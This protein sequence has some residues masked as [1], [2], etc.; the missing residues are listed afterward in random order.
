M[1]LGIKTW[2][3]AVIILQLL[4]VL[5]SCNSPS[6]ES[7]P[8]NVENAVQADFTGEWSTA[9]TY[10][11]FEQANLRIRVQDDGLT[12]VLRYARLDPD[13]SP[14]SQPDMKR[15]FWDGQ[16]QGSTARIELRDEE[17]NVLGQA[18][19]VLQ[20]EELSVQLLQQIPEL[21]EI[22]ILQPSQR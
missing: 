4:F 16:I 17:G 1:Y 21:P 12:G 20:D 13:A 7:L 9:G 6:E 3:A 2:F 22:F 15:Y 5:S 11:A 8:E 10:S 14:E 18:R 19:L